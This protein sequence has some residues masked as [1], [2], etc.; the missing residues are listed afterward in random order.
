[1]F[2]DDQ[3]SCLMDS[4]YKALAGKSMPATEHSQFV[5]TPCKFRDFIHSLFKNKE[6]FPRIGPNLTRRSASG[7][8]PSGHWIGH[9]SSEKNTCKLSLFCCAFLSNLCYDKNKKKT[10]KRMGRDMPCHAN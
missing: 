2:H 6:G 1:M 10:M 4:S 9:R 8:P 7:Q 3:A 5:Y